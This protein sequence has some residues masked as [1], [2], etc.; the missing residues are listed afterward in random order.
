MAGDDFGQID[1]ATPMLIS[2]TENRRRRLKKT[3]GSRKPRSPGV[4]ISR[5]NGGEISNAGDEFR[6][7]DP[8][9]V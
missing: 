1:S 5:G 9:T 4:G 7:T 3:S 6:R 2:T 8:D